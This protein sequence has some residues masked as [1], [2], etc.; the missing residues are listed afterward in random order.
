MALDRL[1]ESEADLM[2]AIELNFVQKDFAYLALADLKF[3]T[4]NYQEALD[5]LYISL[6]LSPDYVETIYLLAKTYFKLGNIPEFYLNLERAVSKR[7]WPSHTIPTD[8]FFRPLLNEERFKRIL[9]KYNIKMK[10]PEKPAEE[11]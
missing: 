4:A 2:R 8:E 10:L 9:Y 6:E 7:S 3:K 11:K 1:A 5:A